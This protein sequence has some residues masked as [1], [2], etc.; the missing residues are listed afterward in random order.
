MITSTSSSTPPSQ[1]WLGLFLGSLI[2]FLAP[3]AAVLGLSVL[4]ESPGGQMILQAEWVKAVVAAIVSYAA[5]EA[6]GR[7]LTTR[8]TRRLTQEQTGEAHQDG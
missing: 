4:D 6:R 8:E 7:V 1:T 2:S 3:G 5:A